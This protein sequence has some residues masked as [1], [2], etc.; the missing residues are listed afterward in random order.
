[1][2]HFCFAAMLLFVLGS[3][4]WAVA[5]LDASYDATPE[6]ACALVGDG[7]S[8]ST[9]DIYERA[10]TFTSVAGGD[11]HSVSMHLAVGYYTDQPLNLDIL[12]VTTGNAPDNTNVLGSASLSAWT[13]DGLYD[14][15]TFDFTGMGVQLTA[16]EMYALVLSISDSDDEYWLGGTWWDPAWTGTAPKDIDPY[17]GGAGWYNGDDSGWILSTDHHKDWWFRV[18]RDEPSN[19]SGAIPEPASILLLGGGLVAA[20][21]RRRLKQQ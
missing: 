3:P 16:G 9:Y 11:V 15:R 1:M 4:V 10:Q 8:S 2:K 21:G 20:L 5:V 14:W 13:Y 17:S 6:D 18:Y 7:S 12:G 19:N